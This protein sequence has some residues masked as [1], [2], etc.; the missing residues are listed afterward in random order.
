MISLIYASLL[1]LIRP[2]P[3][4]LKAKPITFHENFIAI[5]ASLFLGLLLLTIFLF[6][7]D[8]T[9]ETI[10]RIYAAL[11]GLN[12]LKEMAI[13]WPLQWIT[14]MFIHANFLH[15]IS[16]VSILGVLS[17]YE[18]RV[19]SRRFLAVVIVACLTSTASIVFH[20]V[21]SVIYGFSGGICGLG[22]A[23]FTDLKELSIKEWLT[24]VVAFILL[25]VLLSFSN[26]S[27]FDSMN[28]RVDHIGHALGAIGAIIYCRLRPICTASPRSKR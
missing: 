4:S 3:N 11:F 6:T 17:V 26:S 9:F 8:F 22:A 16:N 27:T 24:M 1:L 19:G 2:A 25:F 28:L 12:N 18:R 14:H 7:T 21:P 10:N 20:P 13:L 5:K 15:L 23:Y